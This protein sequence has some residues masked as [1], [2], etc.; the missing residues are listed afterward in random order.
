MEV[1]CIAIGKAIIQE[2]I[3]D[4][5]ATDNNMVFNGVFLQI[6]FAKASFLLKRRR[7]Y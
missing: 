5:P 3:E 2:G 7:Y 6:I 1:A 4:I